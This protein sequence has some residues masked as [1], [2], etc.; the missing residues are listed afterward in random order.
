MTL[1]QVC[2]PNYLACLLLELKCCLLPQEW[3]HTWEVICPSKFVLLTIFSF[4]VDVGY[5][6]YDPNIDSWLQMPI[7]M[8]EGWVARQ[9]GTKLSVTVNDDLYALHPSNS[10]DSAKIRYMIMN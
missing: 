1:I 10:L 7:S 6:I 5:E 8:G 9:A 3:L 2:G 4:S